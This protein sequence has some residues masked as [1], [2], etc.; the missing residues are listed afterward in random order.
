MLGLD[1]ALAAVW[2]VVPLPS[3]AGV[4]PAGDNSHLR[5]RISKSTTS[6]QVQLHGTYPCWQRTGSMYWRACKMNVIITL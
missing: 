2:N 5:A 1:S 4:P 3:A 6:D